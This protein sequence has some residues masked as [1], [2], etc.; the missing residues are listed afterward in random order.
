M[1]N[2]RTRANAGKRSP[3]KIVP[4]TSAVATSAPSLAALPATESGVELH[5]DDE[6][7][8]AVGEEMRCMND[9]IEIIKGNMGDVYVDYEVLYTPFPSTTKDDGMYECQR[10]LSACKFLH[11]VL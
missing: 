10:V 9:V 7:G 1:S 8:G 6:M 4:T 3:L 2:H 5:D 11:F